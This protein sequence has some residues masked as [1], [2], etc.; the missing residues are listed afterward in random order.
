MKIDLKDIA[1]PVPARDWGSPVSEAL[2]IFAGDLQVKFSEDLSQWY[3]SK[4]PKHERFKNKIGV[5]LALEES[6]EVGCWGE[7][8][9]KEPRTLESMVVFAVRERA[10]PNDLSPA[11]F[12]DLKE[13]VAAQLEDIAKKVRRVKLKS[14]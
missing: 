2:R 5:V 12:A 14:K 11:E 4:D 7:G 1:W 3:V 10:Q 8:F 13:A 6:G 9:V